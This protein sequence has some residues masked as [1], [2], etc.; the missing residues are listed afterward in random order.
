[1]FPLVT[2]HFSFFLDESFSW[3]HLTHYEFYG[4]TNLL[5]SYLLKCELMSS[6]EIRK[7]SLFAASAFFLSSG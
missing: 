4:F 2:G 7:M 5:K 1:M 3:S 6:S